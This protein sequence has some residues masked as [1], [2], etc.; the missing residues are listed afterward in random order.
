MPKKCNH[1]RCKR[2]TYLGQRR[3][4]LLSQMVKEKSMTLAE[5]IQCKAMSLRQF[6]I[7]MKTT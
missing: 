3:K 7:D 1:T 5:S 4:F 2:I 6:F